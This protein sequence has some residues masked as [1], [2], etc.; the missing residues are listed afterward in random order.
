L[1]RTQPRAGRAG[2]SSSFPPA[3]VPDQ[4]RCRSARSRR[5]LEVAGSRLPCCTGPPRPPAHL[6]PSSTSDVSGRST[7]PAL[8]RAGHSWSPD[9]AGVLSEH[10][11]S[12][13]A[14]SP[15][16]ALELAED[17][18]VP[19]DFSAHPP[20]PYLQTTIAAPPNSLVHQG[21]SSVDIILR[22][23]GRSSNWFTIYC[24]G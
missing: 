11:R 18:P 21:W 24:R 6:R 1:S 12:G 17:A 7:V 23:H 3:T 14:A 22:V 16:S 4:F 5:A 13:L 10:L 8:H 9:S 20:V 19:L 2:V 15:P